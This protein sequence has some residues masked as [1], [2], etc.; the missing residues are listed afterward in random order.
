M[1]TAL[2]LAYV[3]KDLEHSN[4]EK[5]LIEQC[6]RSHVDVAALYFKAPFIHQQE[7]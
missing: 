6:N 1:G 5:A 4:A 7:A 3:F 2:R